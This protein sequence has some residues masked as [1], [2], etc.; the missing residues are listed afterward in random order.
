VNYIGGIKAAVRTWR[1]TVEIQH[2]SVHRWRRATKRGGLALS[3]LCVAALAAGPVLAS[4]TGPAWR[5]VPGLADFSAVAQN[6]HLVR[7]SVSTDGNIPR[8]ADAF[9][10]SNPVVGLAWA[11]LDSGKVVVA[12]IHP[13]LGRDSHQNPDAWHMHTATLTD[14]A[15]APNDFCI[16]SIA[17]SPTAGIAIRGNTMTVYL[18][19][20]DLP[21]APAAL[22]AATGFT[23]QGDSACTSGLAVRL[24]INP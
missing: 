7:L 23:I 2:G 5:N 20:D 6:D 10:N 15:T 8:R 18:N 3:L 16:V 19:A 17:S 14:G 21:V 22:H 24:V 13:V 12:T 9:V 11:D 1:A 4:G